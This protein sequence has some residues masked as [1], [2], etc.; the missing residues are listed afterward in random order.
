[1]SGDMRVRR[2]TSSSLMTI[3]TI[4]EVRREKTRPRAKTMK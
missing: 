1:M 4:P 3:L 2:H